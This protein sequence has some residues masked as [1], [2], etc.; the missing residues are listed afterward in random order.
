MAKQIKFDQFNFDNHIRRL[1]KVYGRS[2]RAV[3]D[4][5]AGSI[6]K[7][8]IKFTPPY[9]SGHATGATRL[10]I[11]K[12]AIQQQVGNIFQD[13]ETAH[14]FSTKSRVSESIKRLAKEGRINEAEDL[15]KVVTN[16]AA[17]FI[18]RPTRAQHFARTNKYG[19]SRKGPINYV[20]GDGEM[21]SYY[22]NLF[23]RILRGIGGWT[24]GAK[25]LGVKLPARAIRAA[26]WLGVYIPK[27]SEWNYSVTVGNNVPY[28]NDSDRAPKI[29]RRALNLRMGKIQKELKMAS[30]AVLKKLNATLR[31][32]VIPSEAEVMNAIKPTDTSNP[33]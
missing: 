8:C 18:H 4:A 16:S 13:I 15:Y 10:E 1:A 17:S 7:D 30:A 25:Q 31:T 29:I 24:I 22:K 28:L 21:N 5:Q 11:G 19:R 23:G 32:G 14:F 20:V 27:R 26:K 33:F 2:K 12:Q 3:A 9:R 6:L